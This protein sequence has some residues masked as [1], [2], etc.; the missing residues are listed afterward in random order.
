MYKNIYYKVIDQ[1]HQGQK[2]LVNCETLQT[3]TYSD[4]IY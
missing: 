4:S 3:V 1:L 2:I